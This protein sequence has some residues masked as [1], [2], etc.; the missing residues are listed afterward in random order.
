MFFVLRY[1]DRVKADPSKSVVYDL[2][3][4]NEERFQSESEGGA[5]ELTGTHKLILAVFDSRSS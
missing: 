1:A 2:K 3:E 5:I 4:E